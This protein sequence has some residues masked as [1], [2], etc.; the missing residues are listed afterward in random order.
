MSELPTLPEASSILGSIIETAVYTGYLAIEKLMTDEDIIEHLSV[1][2]F[3][4][5]LSLGVGMRPQ[6]QPADK[7]PLQTS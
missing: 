1:R 2:N 5:E 6:Q 7:L 4:G 3:I